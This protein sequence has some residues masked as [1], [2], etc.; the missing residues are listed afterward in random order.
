M[1]LSTKIKNILLKF[2][3]NYYKFFCR[4]KCSSVRWKVK[5]LEDG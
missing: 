5:F 4:V 1:N 3:F 2:V